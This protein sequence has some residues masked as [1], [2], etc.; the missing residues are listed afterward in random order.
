[1]F[2]SIA[3]KQLILH[4]SYA[5]LKDYAS[6]LLVASSVPL[7]LRIIISDL[8]EATYV[9]GVARP[10]I[11]EYLLELI[12]CSREGLTSNELIELIRMDQQR[13]EAS[14]CQEPRPYLEQ[15]SWVQLI[16]SPQQLLAPRKGLYNF[17]HD[18]VR[19]AVEAVYF[20]NRSRF[21]EL[22]TAEAKEKRR[23][24]HRW[25]AIFFEMKSAV[26]N[27]TLTSMDEY[28]RSMRELTYHQRMAEL[29]PS[30]IVAAW[31]RPRS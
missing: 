8:E 5:T 31:V 24:V 23:K 26:D 18:Y 9:G 30:V 27:V 1:M 29:R 7:L 11:I 15:S 16:Y 25:L 17:T 19:Q 13:Q 4:C 14:G 21:D 28:P 10:D 2:L 3:L 22:K 6:K 12:Y 20:G